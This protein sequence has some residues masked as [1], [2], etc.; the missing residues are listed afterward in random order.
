VFVAEMLHIFQFDYQN[1][2]HKLVSLA[3]QVLSP[4]PVCKFFE[5]AHAQCM[6]DLEHGTW[7]S[8][9]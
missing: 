7:H 5:A 8:L 2:G 9:S 3:G 6:G 4:T 1:I